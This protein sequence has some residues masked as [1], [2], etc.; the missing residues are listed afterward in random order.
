MTYGPYTKP[1]HDAE[2]AARRRRLLYGIRSFREEFGYSPTIRELQTVTEVKSTSTVLLD[3]RWLRD[4]GKV[5][6]IDGA[7]RTLREIEE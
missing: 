1:V 4:H 6:W 3:L 5:T 2:V 7:Q